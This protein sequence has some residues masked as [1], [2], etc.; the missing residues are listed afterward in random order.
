M[1]LGYRLALR[2]GL[3]RGVALLGAALMAASPYAVW[4]SQDARMYSMSLCLTLASSWLMLES[5]QRGRRR[6]WVAYLLVTWAALF[7]HYFAL[8]IVAA[9]N[10][11]VLGRALLT[12]RMG[13]PVTQW[14]QYQIVLVFFALPWFLTAQQTLTG[15]GGNGSSPT[16]LDMAQRTLGA[17]TVGESL[18]AEW[19]LLFGGTGA[20]LVALA[21]WS[22]WR[23]GANQ[24]RTLALLLLLWLVPVLTTWISA[25]SRPIFDER[26]LIAA[27]PAFYL[28]VA[29]GIGALHRRW[30]ILPASLGLV[31]AAGMILSLG[32]H[33]FDPAYSKTRGWRELA[34]A[35]ERFSSALPEEQVR[36]AQN[37]PDPTIW[38][39]YNGP[40]D[41]IVLPPQPNDAAG[42]AE[43]V[44]KLVAEDVQ[45]VILP[46][47][48]ADWW[49]GSG[50]APAALAA[51][52]VLAV[53]TQIGVW[54]LHVYTRP[55]AQLSPL[56]VTFANG[57]AVRDAAVLPDRIL[58]GGV[59]T[60]HLR[61]GGQTETLTGNE[62]IF[63]HLIDGSGQIAAQTDQ[64]LAV[65]AIDDPVSSYGILLPETLA[66]GPYVLVFGLYDPSLDGAP[67]ILT[68]DGRDKVELLRREGS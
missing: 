34:A 10:V 61:W 48:A 62:K 14:I 16:F 21:I 30:R 22:L 56:E 43:V 13:I 68:E 23:Q 32:N 41:H 50:I 3:G 27:S 4:H 63:L 58:N 55:P 66:A 7:T 45:R 20:I 57:L 36:L 26:Y 9:Q 15:Y 52:Y 49:D 8:F 11:F 24:Q 67:R 46:V 65:P 39:Y 25:Q 35:F 6:L 59:L 47:Q 40:V 18:P 64:P 19:R 29:A 42:A 28:L 12:R 53:E 5:L 38:Y 54:P 60:V 2:L 1:A 31:L 51:E 37:F 44:D 33:Y 17:F